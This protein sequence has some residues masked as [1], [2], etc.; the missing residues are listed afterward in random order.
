MCILSSTIVMWIMQ[1]KFLWIFKT[2][3]LSCM[4]RMWGDFW[5]MKILQEDEKSDFHYFNFTRAWAM[6]SENQN[7]T[8]RANTFTII[9]LRDWYLLQNSHPLQFSV[10]TVVQWH[11]AWLL[12]VVSTSNQNDCNLCIAFTYVKVSSWGTRLWCQ[13]SWVQMPVIHCLTYASVNSHDCQT[14]SNGLILLYSAYR[15]PTPIIDDYDYSKIDSN[16]FITDNS[17][18]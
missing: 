8:Y 9:L 3:L 18:S 6:F 10:L 1:K 7:L 11:G 12:E 5:G 16:E 14:N 13:K 15:N 2:W 4:Y 17:S